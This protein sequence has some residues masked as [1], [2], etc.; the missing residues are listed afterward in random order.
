M[1]DTFAS[2]NG[3]SS[4]T[5]TVGMPATP[6]PV[7]PPHQAAQST[8]PAPTLSAAD[9]AAQL[10][11]PGF[12]AKFNS[13]DPAVRAEAI[14]TSQRLNQIISGEQ[15]NPHGAPQAAAEPLPFLHQPGDTTEQI[16]SVRRA[17]DEAARSMQAPRELAT[18]FVD[19]IRRGQSERLVKGS[20]GRMTARVMDAGEQQAM[21]GDLQRLWGQNY[22]ARVDDALAALKASGAH[23]QWILSSV[24]SSGARNAAQAWAMLA[25]HGQR[26]RAGR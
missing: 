23:G 10:R 21:R 15:A 14:A 6:A 25:D 24:M 18:S 3:S 1:T 19:T 26:L 20:D 22:T 13:P 4:Y 12:A 11:D 17:G 9:A 7:A 8:A 16:D 5:G 2:T